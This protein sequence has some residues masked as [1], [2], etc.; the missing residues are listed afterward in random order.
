MGGMRL[1]PCAMIGGGDGGTAARG[2]CYAV[3]DPNISD[4][5][6]KS[7]INRRFQHDYAICNAQ[8]E[9]MAC[10]GDSLAM[11]HP[12][13]CALYSLIFMRLLAAGNS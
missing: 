13:L 2:S 12:A 6:K 1:D 3:N 7:L 4:Q 10:G 5:T 9:I 8:S 11:L